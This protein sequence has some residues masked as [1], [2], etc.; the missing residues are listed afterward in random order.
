M[1]ENNNEFIAFD[2]YFLHEIRNQNRGVKADKQMDMI[3]H[4]MDG[5]HLCFSI[6][7]PGDSAVRQT[8]CKENAPGASD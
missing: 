1:L 3:G 8:V 7:Y 5:K 6:L 4:T 2:F